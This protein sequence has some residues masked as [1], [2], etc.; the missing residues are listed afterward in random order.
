MQSLTF[1]LKLKSNFLTPSSEPLAKKRKRMCPTVE[2]TDR[3]PSPAESILELPQGR[4]PCQNEY[5]LAIF[6]LIFN[7]NVENS[8]YSKLLNLYNYKSYIFNLKHN[9]YFYVTVKMVGFFFTL[10]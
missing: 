7:M 10:G 9:S 1:H 8:L 4:K 6:L 2:M 5:F 3:A